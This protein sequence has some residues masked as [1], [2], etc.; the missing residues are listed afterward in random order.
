MPNCLQGSPL[1]DEVNPRQI[2]ERLLSIRELSELSG[3]SQ[4]SIRREIHARRL[5]SYRPTN[6]ATAPH[7]VAPSEWGRWLREVAAVR[8]FLPPTRTGVRHG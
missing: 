3:V 8:Q 2:I 4:K 5:S 6:G 1:G 7:L